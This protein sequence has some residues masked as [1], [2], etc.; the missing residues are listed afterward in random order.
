MRSTR[1]PSPHYIALSYYLL[2][3][4]FYTCRTSLGKS[5]PRQKQVVLTTRM[6]LELMT[7]IGGARRMGRIGV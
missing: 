6:P 2:S 1:N 5:C 7:H 3:L 4:P